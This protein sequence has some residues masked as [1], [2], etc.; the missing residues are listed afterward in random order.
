MELKEINE[1][2][3]FYVRPQTFPLAI[4]MCQSAEE[5]PQKARL[6]KRNMGFP[7]TVCQGIGMARRYGWTLAV[8]KDEE[9]CP[10]GAL[11][12]GFVPTKDK[13]VDGSFAESLSRGSGAAAAR[14]AEAL[15]RL[16]YGK[17]S[18]VLISPLH[19]VTF[20]PHVVVIYG[21]SAQVMRLVQ[22]AVYE[23]GGYLTSSAAGGRDCADIISQTMLS[24][25]CQF[26]LPCNGDRIFGM[27]QDHEMAFSMPWSRVESTIR[28]LKAGHES[29]LQRY[30]I[31][32]YLRFEAALP[33]SYY[34]LMDYLKQSP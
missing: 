13:F 7:V 8:G 20:E 5:I 29:G 25:E 2:L 24:G 33:P 30:P 11:A 15:P 23:R 9:S 18:H 31:P 14:S 32:S 22:G 6:P 4:R 16:E 3:S 26:V 17:Y 34:K 21:D 27:A 28:G 12:L 10:Y 19:A 1:A